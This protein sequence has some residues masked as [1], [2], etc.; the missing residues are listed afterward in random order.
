MIIGEDTDLLIAML[1]Y[2]RNQSSFKLIYKYDKAAV[3]WKFGH[4]Y[5]LRDFF[6]ALCDNY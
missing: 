1:L 4:C 6:D 5:F 2:S 3:S